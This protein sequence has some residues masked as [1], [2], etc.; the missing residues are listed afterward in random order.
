M[1]RVSLDWLR[2]N[3]NSE[4]NQMEPHL[5]HRGG[6]VFISGSRTSA[7]NSFLK[8]LRNIV[9]ASDGLSIQLYP[10]DSSTRTPIDIVAKLAAKLAVNLDE[11]GETETPYQVL[12]GLY[13]GGDIKIEDV[14]VKFEGAL[15]SKS[16]LSQHTNIV[17]C[18]FKK[19]IENDCKVLLIL[20]NWKLAPED[21]VFWFWNGLWSCGLEE[22]IEK[23]LLVVCAGE[24]DFQE[25]LEST[26]NNH[27][28]KFIQ[29]PE[30][31][32]GDSLETA[33]DDVAVLIGKTSN[34]SHETS[35]AIA[36]SLLVNWEYYPSQLHAKL[37]LQ[38]YL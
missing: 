32:Q 3:W 10:E 6:L 11:D 7:C 5:Y 29:L 1:R 19:T 20:Y 18:E 24:M 33:I 8:L 21:C 23:G 17:A 12:H 4:L 30:R 13:A 22:L 31:Y 9:E 35:R 15:N 27:P 37:P 36:R 14:N 25:L 28:D 38:Q 16:D 26:L 2:I 34:H